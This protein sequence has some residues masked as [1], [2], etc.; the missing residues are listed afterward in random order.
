MYDSQV[1]LVNFL[2]LLKN[3]KASIGMTS[4]LGFYYENQVKRNSNL[5]VSVQI[6]FLMTQ[7]TVWFWFL[8]RTQLRILDRSPTLEVGA[9]GV[10][11]FNLADC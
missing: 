1:Y 5:W 4:S 10:T 3:K 6:G 11:P 8:V 2:I 7:R 9:G